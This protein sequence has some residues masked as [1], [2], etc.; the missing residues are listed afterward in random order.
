MENVMVMGPTVCKSLHQRSTKGSTVVNG[1]M[2]RSMYALCII[3]I[4]DCKTH[5]RIVI[6]IYLDLFRDMGHTSTT[7]WQSMR[8]SGKRTNGVDGEG[9]TMKMETS[10]RGSG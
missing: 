6:Y 7:A 4:L 9:C 5:A 1:K 2:E 3:F 8:G 10:M